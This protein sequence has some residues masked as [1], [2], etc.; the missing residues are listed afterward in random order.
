M[1]QR[2]DTLLFSLKRTRSRSE[3]ADLIKRNK[4]RVNG[5]VINKPSIE[6]TPNDLIEIDEKQYV[7][8]GAYKLLKAL[9]YFKIDVIKKKA[10]DIGSSTGGFTEVLLEKGASHVYSID[11]GTNQLDSKLRDDLRVT[12]FESTDIRN[13]KKSQLTTDI[14]IVV[15]D[16]SFI[17]LSHILPLLHTLIDSADIIA[18]FKPQFEV[19]KEYVRK[20]GIVKDQRIVDI[21]LDR[22]RQKVKELGFKYIGCTESPIKGGDGNT[23][24]LLHIQ[25]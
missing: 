16:V 5:K 3:A 24:Y 18:L 19:G 13:V 21:S 11:S 17:S 25:M 20:N 1:K 15:I 23:E 7:S 22:L 8:R 2:L 10:L 4:V 14:H 6:Y 9:D 12:L